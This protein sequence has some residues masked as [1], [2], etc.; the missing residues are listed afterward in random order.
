MLHNATYP[1]HHSVTTLYYAEV[2][3][4]AISM[5]V[6]K[7]ITTLCTVRDKSQN[8]DMQNRIQEVF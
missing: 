3:I 1:N 2:I 7:S 5:H 4:C 6:A 8:L